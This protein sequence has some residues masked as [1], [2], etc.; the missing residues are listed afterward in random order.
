M[1]K[2][3]NFLLDLIFPKFCYGCQKQGSYLCQDCQSILNV[4]EYHQPFKTEYLDDLYF[5]I[6]YKTSGSSYQDRLIH[7][8]IH[9][10]KYY[11]FVRELS[12]PL[13]DLIINHFQLSEKPTPFNNKEFL[14]VP[15]PSSQKRK[16]WRGYN[17]AEEIANHLSSY[18]KI[19]MINNI[20]IK[21]KETP[22]QSQLNQK[23]REENILD[24]FQS[25]TKIKKNILL[26]D[27]VYTTGATINECAKTLKK[28]GAKKVIALTIARTQSLPS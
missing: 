23:E 16:K 15:V 20:L 18:L 26:V 19:K 14:I 25:K 8:L 3:K 5:S 27:D 9:K 2:V 13:S 28:S 4:N 1:K 22:F 10:F 21:K 12:Q 7:L 6:A 24:S 11:P 17:Q